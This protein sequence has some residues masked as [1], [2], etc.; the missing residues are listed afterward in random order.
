MAV[1]RTLKSGSMVR[2]S[3]S[4]LPITAA[5]GSIWKPRSRMRPPAKRKISDAPGHSR[6]SATLSTA[7]RSGLMQRSMFRRSVPNREQSSL[8]SSG[9]RMRAIRMGTLFCA[10]ASRQAI[11]FASSLFVTAMTIS[12][13]AM[14]ARFR[15]SGLLPLPR[16]VCMSSAS[17]ISCSRSSFR[18]MTTT[19][20][21]SRERLSAI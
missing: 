13:W 3:E 1:I 5:P 2:S 21:P 19:S 11:M 17:E 7:S 9:L 16:T 4:F 6:R 10:D 12:A 8:P 15:I 14:F 18:S 20:F